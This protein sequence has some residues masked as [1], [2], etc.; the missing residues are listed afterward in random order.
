MAL[1][2]TF[3]SML[4]RLQR[5]SDRLQE[6]RMTVVEDKPRKCESALV[7][8][9]EGSVLDTEGLLKEVIHS[10]REAVGATGSPVDLERG[11]Q[12]LAVCQ[13]RFHLIQR[14][15]WLDLCSYRRLRDLETLASQRGG[16]WARWAEST[17]QGIERCR[18]PL[19]EAS[20]ALV[21]C[22]QELAE[23][24][25]WINVSVQSTDTGRRIE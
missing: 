23:R 22:W 10:A 17:K 20:E 16:E 18:Q 7:D 3:T 8:N 9:L 19:D 4:V 14:Q 2:A 12:A 5:L 13:M 24:Q 15:F 25:S 1:E 6:V 11:R 21:A